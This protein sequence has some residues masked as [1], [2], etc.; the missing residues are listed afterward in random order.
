MRLKSS[1]ESLR[2]DARLWVIGF[3]LIMHYGAKG[4]SI[5]T[6]H[7]HSPPRHHRR[8]TQL[9]VT[10]RSERIDRRPL[11]L[12]FAKLLD[13]GRWFDSFQVATKPSKPTNSL[14]NERLPRPGSPSSQSAIM[15]SCIRTT[16]RRG[17][18]PSEKHHP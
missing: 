2:T 14:S 8:L 6:A 13:S 4:E 18:R 11:T 17:V 7:Q 1:M 15:R 16:D 12:S 10:H 9:G 5:L 3:R